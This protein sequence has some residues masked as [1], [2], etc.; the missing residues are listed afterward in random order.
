MKCV[1]TVTKV[2]NELKGACK[3]MSIL[4]VEKL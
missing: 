2:T 1:G 4:K 3:I